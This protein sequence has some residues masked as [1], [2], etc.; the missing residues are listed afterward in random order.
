MC[1]RMQSLDGGGGRAEG[2]DGAGEVTGAGIASGC[3]S[4]CMTSST[5]SSL[6]S[7]SLLG[8]EEH[9]AA[10]LQR[11]EDAGIAASGSCG[12]GGSGM[13][14]MEPGSPAAP[15]AGRGGGLGNERPPGHMVRQRERSSAASTAGEGTSR[16]VRSADCDGAPKRVWR[17]D[18]VPPANGCDCRRGGDK[19]EGV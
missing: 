8:S 14:L 11:S 13:S 7:N 2:D 15:I 9:C 12:S 16:L 18:T 5:S 6:E 1:G 19:G 3:G 4:T 10:E 17:R